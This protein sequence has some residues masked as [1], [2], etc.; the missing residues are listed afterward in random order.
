[1]LAN[2]DLS[3]RVTNVKIATK[4]ASCQLQ[5][6]SSAVLDFPFA[7]EVSFRNRQLLPLDLVRAEAFSIIN[8]RNN[9]TSVQV[10]FIFIIHFPGLKSNH[11]YGTYRVG[12]A[13]YYGSNVNVPYADDVQ[14]NSTRGERG[15]RFGSV[16]FTI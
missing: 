1:M 11:D 14:F 7:E 10:E 3:R 13:A 4:A 12:I 8:L 5:L 15:G 16:S 9:F 2:D 6:P